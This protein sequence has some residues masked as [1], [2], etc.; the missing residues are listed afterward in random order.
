MCALTVTVRSSVV[1]LDSS[2]GNAVVTQQSRTGCLFGC[3][4]WLAACDVA[5]DATPRYVRA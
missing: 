3:R 1:E 2:E 4:E 5:S